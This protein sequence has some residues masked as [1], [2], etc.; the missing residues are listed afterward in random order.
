MSRQQAK[1][2]SCDPW[3]T[4]ATLSL[5]MSLA[6]LSSPGSL[7]AWLSNWPPLFQVK[8]ALDTVS[9]KIATFTDVGNSL[10]H[11]EHLLKDLASFEEKSS[12]R[13]GTRAG[14][15]PPAPTAASGTF[16]ALGQPLLQSSGSFTAPIPPTPCSDVSLGW[17]A[18][19]ASGS[20]GALA[21]VQLRDG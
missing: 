10:A 21:P 16:P 1:T 11:V 7:L 19:T 2:R 20:T 8:T 13:R 4:G 3:W 17:T 15:L 14:E 9:Q 18:P 5:A 6:S 12:V